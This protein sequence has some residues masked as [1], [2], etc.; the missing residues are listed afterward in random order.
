[1]KKIFLV[2][3]KASYPRLGPIQKELEGRGW[4]VYIPFTH[5]RPEAESQWY[6]Q[7]PEEHSRMKSQLFHRSRERIL[8]MDAVLTLNFDKDGQPNYIGGSTFLELYE[9]FMAGKKIYLWN[10]IP[11]GLLYDEISAFSPTVIHGDVT[12]VTP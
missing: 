1:M 5:D 9:A 12:L 8:V 2:C 11:Q 3:S 7:G 4:E 10:D 6:A